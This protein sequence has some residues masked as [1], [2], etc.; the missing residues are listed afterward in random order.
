MHFCD[1][2]FCCALPAGP[3]RPPP[4]PGGDFFAHCESI[5]FIYMKVFSFRDTYLPSIRPEIEHYLGP[6]LIIYKNVIF[7]SPSILPA[8]RVSL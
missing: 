5:S 8:L 2:Y 7:A 4:P 6:I 1:M 3:A